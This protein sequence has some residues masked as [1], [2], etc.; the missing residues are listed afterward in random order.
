MLKK[1]KKDIEHGNNGKS[2]AMGEVVGE[3][4]SQHSIYLGFFL[5]VKSH[6]NIS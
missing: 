5:Q 2:I 4:G 3:W 6:Y 1:G